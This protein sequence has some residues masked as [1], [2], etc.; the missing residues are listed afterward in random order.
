MAFKKQRM[1][2]KKV[3]YFTKTKSKQSTTRIL[4]Y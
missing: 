2:R 3:C 4:N 1:G